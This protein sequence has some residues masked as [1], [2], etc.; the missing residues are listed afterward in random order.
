MRNDVNQKGSPNMQDISYTITVTAD[1]N[2]R[3]AT[4]HAVYSRAELDPIVLNL[5]F[6]HLACL[7]LALLVEATDDLRPSRLRVVTTEP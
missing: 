5:E 4:K 6:E 1:Q 7:L 3:E 2:G